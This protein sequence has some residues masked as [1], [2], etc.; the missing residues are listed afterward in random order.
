MIHP[1]T[2]RFLLEGEGFREIDTKY[3]SKVGEDLRI[4]QVE[5]LPEEFNH[6][7]QN[8]N[9]LVYGYR[10]YAIIGRK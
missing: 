10:D 1:L 7:L 8:L 5:S 2:I 4:P 6:S 9:N 3:L